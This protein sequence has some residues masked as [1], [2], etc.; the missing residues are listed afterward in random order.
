[1]RTLI[2]TSS[3]ALFFLVMISCN[4]FG[5]SPKQESDLPVRFEISSIRSLSEEELS[6]RTGD[7]ITESG[8][9]LKC[10]VSNQGRQTVYLYTAF[11]NSIV[12]SGYLVTKTDKGLAWLL[13]A[14]GKTSTQS[15]GFSP[16]IIS[17]GTWLMLS[18]GD[19]VEW[20]KIQQNSSAEEIRA[21]T[22]FMKFG[23]SEKV[24][25]IFSDFYKTP[26]K[27]SK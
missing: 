21:V 12:P 27:I 10:R 16:K 9:A 22:V 1:M 6:R 26:V 11:A 5:Q 7:N 20:E 24:V 19:A 25:E 14:S 23:N 18:E 15:P 17:S 3:L 2:E 13:N 8:F 4:C